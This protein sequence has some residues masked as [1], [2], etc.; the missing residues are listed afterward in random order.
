MLYSTF[1]L[2]IDYFLLLLIIITVYHHHHH[3][4]HHQSVSQVQMN[5]R[6]ASSAT[7]CRTWLS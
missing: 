3:H 7:P 5:L 2:S 4:Y 6:S 1:L